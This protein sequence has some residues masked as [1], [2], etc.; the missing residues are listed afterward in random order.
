MKVIPFG[1]PLG[2]VNRLLLPATTSCGDSSPP[3]LIEI[4]DTL[5]RFLAV[6][7]AASKSVSKRELASDLQNDIGAPCTEGMRPFNVQRSL[8]L[9]IAGGVRRRES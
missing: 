3:K 8:H 7:I 6:L 4:T 5:G 1:V 2:V 9:V